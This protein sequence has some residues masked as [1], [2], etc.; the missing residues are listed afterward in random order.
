MGD[1]EALIKSRSSLPT[2]SR[3]KDNERLK[4]DKGANLFDFI[5]MVKILVELHMP[6][7]EF[8]P[9][10][11]K[12]YELDAMNKI[13]KTIITYRVKNRYPS[14]ELKPRLMEEKNNDKEEVVEIWTQNFEAHVQFNIFS[15]VYKDAEQVMERFEEIILFHAGFIKKNGI[16]ELLF[17]EHLT[18]SSFNTLRETL[19]VRN[20]LYYVRIQKTTVM[21]KEKIEEIELIAQKKKDEEE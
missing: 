8:C 19:S 6:E 2:K 12:M 20:L 14:N 3:N 21:L 10:E 18:D 1:L 11:G 17:K 7:V 4:A 16:S 9:D 15:S 13:D 5:K